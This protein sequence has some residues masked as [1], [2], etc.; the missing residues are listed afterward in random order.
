MKTIIKAVSVIAL[1]TMLSGCIVA[2]GHHDRGW[3][4][5][6]H[7]HSHGGGHGGGHH[8]GW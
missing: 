2:P 4:G 3:H 5:G 7:G 8:R 1:M 6:G